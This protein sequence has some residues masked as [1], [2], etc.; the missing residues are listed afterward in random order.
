MDRIKAAQVFIDVSLTESF[1]ASA[2]RLQ[3]SRPMVTRYIEALEDWLNVRLL[4]R[5]TRKVSLTTQGEL[6]L[7]D[8]RALL[9]QA[10]LLEQKT[11]N[12]HQL[13]G[14]IK[15]AA[16]MSFG[17]ALL[18]PALVGFM[19][20]HPQVNIDIALE[21]KVSDL[22][23]QQIDL[24]FR[25]A[26]D[27]DPSLMGKPIAP[28]DSVIVAAPGYLK[29]SDPIHNPQDLQQH[30]CVSYRNFERNVWHL[31]QGE[32]FESVNIHSQLTCNEATAL[33]TAC[34]NGAG[35]ALLPSYL[36]SPH[37]ASG[38]LI[39]LLPQWQPQAMT[40]YAL[41]SSRKH[42]SPIVRALIDYLTDYFKTN[43]I[44]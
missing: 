2:D 33:L 25:I 17:H 24:A 15:I 44:D 29:D 22:T 13:S 27:P 35:I 9:E 26:S 21:D 36:A 5:T 30:I 31:Q 12:S 18:T 16:S 32:Q 11:H 43:L 41:Y 20:Q 23:R 1:T 6:Y 7:P 37:L 34:L 8:I 14:S 42:L 3:M 40:V 38:Q 28:C 10:E 19:Q 39:K 4:H